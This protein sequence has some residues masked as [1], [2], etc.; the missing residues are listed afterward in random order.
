MS[1]RDLCE[2]CGAGDMQAVETILARGEVDV[3]GGGQYGY[4]PLIYAMQYNQASIVTRLLSIPH[5]RLDCTN[6]YGRTA[7]HYACVY[8][9]ASVIAIFGQDSRCS[10]AILNM[11]NSMGWTAVMMAVYRGHLDCVKEMDKLEGTNF[12][13]KNYAGDTLVDVARQEGHEMVL[14]YLLGR[15]ETLTDIAAYNV[16]KYIAREGDVGALEIP[17]GLKNVVTKYLDI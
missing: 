1:I 15:V 7:L 10:P 8:N 16:A 5:I 4:T 14:E 6:G 17:R 12:R 9:R 11:R 2:A 3:N 13:T